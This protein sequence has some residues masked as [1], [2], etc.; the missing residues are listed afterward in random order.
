MKM[1]LSPIRSELLTSDKEQACEVADKQHQNQSRGG[2][3]KKKIKGK[4]GES[5]FSSGGAWRS[6][7][8]HPMNDTGSK[9][10]G[11]ILA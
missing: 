11:Q 10:E 9:N 6:P 5:D 7:N 8:R 4:I 1:R 2:N 3:S